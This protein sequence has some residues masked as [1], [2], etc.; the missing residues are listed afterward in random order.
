[1]PKI[2]STIA[3]MPSCLY[4][5]MCSRSFAR[6]NPEVRPEHGG[7][8]KKCH[9]LL[10][11]GVRRR[12]RQLL[13]I[14]DRL[15]FVPS[16]RSLIENSQWC[17]PAK[18]NVSNVDLNVVR[19]QMGDRQSPFKNR[20]PLSRCRHDDTLVLSRGFNGNGLFNDFRKL[21]L[22]Q[23]NYGR[24]RSQ[25]G[26]PT[27]APVT[28]LILTSHDLPACLG[29][30]LITRI[31]NDESL[32]SHAKRNPFIQNLV[33]DKKVAESLSRCNWSSR[34]VKLIFDHLGWHGCFGF[35]QTTSSTY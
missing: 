34:Q 24:R 14:S 6:Q 9:R 10:N 8:E 30:R 12:Q 16:L 23:E 17:F 5:R 31:Q 15:Y 3:A 13:F 19:M 4:G 26:S 35:Q 20:K 11:R 32:R 25:R 2:S 27:S 1:M 22:S 7:P 28:P 18:H 21:K 33:L 29:E